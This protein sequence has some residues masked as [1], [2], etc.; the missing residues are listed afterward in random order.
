LPRLHPSAEDAGGDG[1]IA[2]FGGD[3]DLAAELDVGDAVPVLVDNAF[4]DARAAARVRRVGGEGSR[5][6]PMS[7]QE[8]TRAEIDL[9]RRLRAVRE[10]RPDPVPAAALEEMLDVARWTGTASNRQHWELVVIEERATLRALAG[11]EGYAAHLAGAPLGIALV[12]AGELPEQETFDEGRL[13]ERIM[14]AAEAHGLGSCIGWLRGEGQTAAK[15]LLGVPSEKEL[16]TFLS[17]GYPD[18][19]ARRARPV[20]REARKPLGAFVH[21]ERYGERPE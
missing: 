10:F 17:V 20:N 13:A 21:R 14:L 4:V 7:D 6:K 19:A 15:R 18:E 3:V 16:R 1:R 9:L 12:M 5:G 8:T 2:D 11:M